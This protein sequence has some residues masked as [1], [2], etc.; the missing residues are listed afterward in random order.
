[1]RRLAA[2]LFLVVSGCGSIGSVQAHNISLAYKAGDTYKYALHAVLD[3][4]IGAEGFSVPFNLDMT[5]KETITV[6]SVDSSGTADLTISLTDISVKT[7]TNGTTNTTT[8]T[9][10]TSVEMKVASDG[11]IVSVNGSTFTNGRYVRDGRAGRNAAVPVR[12]R[13]HR[14]AGPVDEGD[15]DLRRDLV[16]RLGRP[17]RRQDT[18]HGQGRRDHAA[19]HDRRRHH[20][21]SDGP[22]HFQGHADHGHEPCLTSTRSAAL[23]KPSAGSSRSSSRQRAGLRP[24]PRAGRLRS[25]CFTSACGASGSSTPWSKSAKAGPTRRHRKTSISSTKQSWRAGSA[26][27]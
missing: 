5:G 26:R 18:L 9:T 7:T 3:Y 15:D 14:S 16:D 24:R 10:P 25:S 12:R 20:A 19:Q 2:V 4:T 23:S 11:R 8:T 6:K 21:G 1:M 13:P 17:S 22:D 27:P